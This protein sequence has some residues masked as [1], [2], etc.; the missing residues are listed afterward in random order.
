MLIKSK[1]LAVNILALS[2]LFTA[3]SADAARTTCVSNYGQCGGTTYTGATNC[4]N[5]NFYC[6]TQ[7]AYWA[8]CE[9]KTTSTT[10]AP[11]TGKT[12]TSTT[13]STSSKTTSTS[14]KQT[15][16][17]SS[18]STSTS[19]STSTSSTSCVPNYSQCGG[20][21]YTGATNCCNSNF[22]C[23]TQ[24]AYWA[25]C[26][27]RTSTTLS[28]STSASTST[29]SSSTT[30]TISNSATGSST[31]YCFVTGTYPSSSAVPSNIVYASCS[32]LNF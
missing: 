17:S 4:C 24:N 23:S 11:T 9:S 7:N 27:T 19:C 2:F 16:S 30:S 29:S 13:C 1:L 25:G 3:Q 14:L 28:V 22:Y 12:S 31:S 6:S 20:T 10:I 15:T 32:T 21:T 8:G 5:S 18:T 26:E